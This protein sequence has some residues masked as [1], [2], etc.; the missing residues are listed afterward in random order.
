MSR[1]RRN[2]R[3]ATAFV[4]A[5]T[6]AALVGVVAP[7]AGAS[8]SGAAPSTARLWHEVAG[9]PAPNHA[10]HDVSI[11]AVRMRTF[12]LDR[13]GMAS[14]LTAAPLEFTSAARS[15]PMTIAI[16]GPSKGFQRFAIQESPVMEPGLA[17]KHPEIKTYNG[18]GIDDPA[19]T[20]RLDLTPLGFHASVRGQQGTWF[21]DPYYHLDQSLYAVYRGGDLQND[22]GSFVDH[23]VK[24]LVSSQDLGQG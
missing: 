2:S 18:R 17:L 5:L 1:S 16:P 6:L 11:H 9:R 3:W 22:H 19:A 13:A 20:I 15:A 7:P 8:P 12:T 14:A 23:Q 21:V 4:A 24:R 10:G